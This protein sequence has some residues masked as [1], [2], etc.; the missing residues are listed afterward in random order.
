[1]RFDGFPVADSRDGV[2]ICTSHP[3][4]L[5][6]Q[7]VRLPFA[8]RLFLALRPHLVHH[9]PSPVKTYIDSVLA[10][11]FRKYALALMVVFPA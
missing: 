3:A 4:G 9:H 8:Q 10:L 1:M 2:L 7:R 6:I 11:L 5:L